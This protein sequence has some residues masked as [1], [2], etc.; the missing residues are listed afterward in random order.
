[1][2]PLVRTITPLLC[3]RCAAQAE[4]LYTTVNEP[5]LAIAMYKKARMYDH[6][7]RLVS[8]YRKDLL[9]DT[10]MHLAQQLE[11]EA[12]GGATARSRGRIWCLHVCTHTLARACAPSGMHV[13]ICHRAAPLGYVWFTFRE[14]KFSSSSIPSPRGRA[15]MNLKEAETHF[16]EAG[17]WEAAVNMYRSNDLW[18]EAFRVAKTHGGGPAASRVACVP[19][20]E[21]TVRPRPACDLWESEWRARRYA[22]ALALGGDAGSKLLH[23]LGMIEQAIECARWR[24]RWHAPRIRAPRTRARA[25]VCGALSVPRARPRARRY[26]IETQAFDHAFEL[27]RTSLKKKVPHVHLKHALFLEDEGRCARLG[28]VDSPCP[29]PPPLCWC[30]TRV[31]GLPGTRR[32][33]RSS[34]R[35]RSRRRR[36]TCTST[37][38]TGRPRCASLRRAWRARQRISPR[39]PPRTTNGC[40]H[41]PRARAQVRP[42]GDL[43]RAAGAGARRGRSEGPRARGGALRGREEAGARAARVSAPR[44]AHAAA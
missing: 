18:D 5:D 14:C 26:A 10:H 3:A 25:A 8:K 31:S 9:K 30:L 33:R 34:S 2:A 27:A 44:H 6:M 17:D 38:A 24:A 16:V 37:S 42:D 11:T 29:P 43:R 35:R 21:G 39:V 13:P 32:R 1:M 28:G 4:R 41:N 19:R 23:K 40:A 7:V 22:W 12:R 20:R 15:Q 36:S